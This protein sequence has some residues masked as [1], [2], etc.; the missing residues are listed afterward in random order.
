MVLKT[1]NRNILAAE[2]LLVGTQGLGIKYQG[3]LA[4]AD[5]Q[6]Y[7]IMVHGCRQ[8]QLNIS[9]H[10]IEWILTQLQLSNLKPVNL[11]GGF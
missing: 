4:E 9:L 8:C 1:A 11:A 7:R 10:M 2:E 3:L 6:G 5:D